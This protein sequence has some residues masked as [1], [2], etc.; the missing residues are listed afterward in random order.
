MDSRN[1][2][3]VTVLMTL[4]NKGPYVLG[5]IESV[6]AN[7]YADF[8]LLVVDDASTDGGLALVEGSADERIRILRSERNQGRAATANRGLEAAR[9]ELI[10]VLDADD[11]MH[12]DR[13]FQ[14]VQ[15]M[16]AHP[17]VVVCGSWIRGFGHADNLHRTPVDDIGARSIMLFGVPVSYGTAMFRKSAVE[18]HAVRCRSDWRTPGMDYLFVLELGKYGAYA[19]IQNVLTEYRLGEQNMRHGRDPVADDRILFKAVLELFE[20]SFTEQDL[21]AH[22]ALNKVLPPAIKAGS[23]R[24][25]YRWCMKLKHQIALKN[26]RCSEAFN[27]QVDRRWAELYSILLAR[28]TKAAL[29]HVLLDPT[30]PKFRRWV[31]HL[32]RHAVGR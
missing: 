20:I 12:K 28:S 1:A 26:W 7:T 10:A 13:L 5:A 2:P 4:Y 6:L 19:N 11:L 9:G 21:D 29:M 16:D 14:Q 22:L 24:T 27:D 15:F 23:V 3:R 18:L 17:D 8:E 32:I 31:G 30:L 25:A